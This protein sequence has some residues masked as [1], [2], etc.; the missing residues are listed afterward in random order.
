M[1]KHSQLALYGITGAL[2]L[3]I[4]GCP[5]SEDEPPK[6]TPDMSSP[7]DMGADLA[8]QPD[9]ADPPDQTQD[10]L[11]CAIIKK[12][13]ARFELTAQAQQLTLELRCTAQ[14]SLSCAQAPCASLSRGEQL[15]P[16]EL[17]EQ[18]TAAGRFDYTTTL[19]DLVPPQ[20]VGTEEVIITLPGLTTPLREQLRWGIP[21]DELTAP[22]AETSSQ[23][24]PE[25]LST[26][27]V[28]GLRIFNLEQP[29]EPS[30]AGRGQL[31]ALVSSEDGASVELWVQGSEDDQARMIHTMPTPAQTLTNGLLHITPSQ[32][33]WIGVDDAQG[34]LVGLYATFDEALELVSAQA[35][36]S[37][38]DARLK[39][40]VAQLLATDAANKP[41]IFNLGFKDNATLTITKITD[42]V[43]APLFSEIKTLGGV[44]VSAISQGSVGFLELDDANQPL[45]WLLNTAQGKTQLI[46]ASPQQDQPLATIEL[47]ATLDAPHLERIVDAQSRTSALVLISGATELLVRR[48]DQGQWAAPLALKHPRHITFKPR[49]ADEPAFTSSATFKILGQTLVGLGAGP[50][51]ERASYAS[52][53]D[54]SS[55]EL[56]QVN[57]LQAS[58]EPRSSSDPALVSA[59]DQ[60]M[61]KATPLA[62]TCDLTADRGLCLFKGRCVQ[63]SPPSKHDA[64]LCLMADTSGLQVRSAIMHADDEPRLAQASLGQPLWFSTDYNKETGLAITV[65]AA[66]D[67]DKSTHTLWRVEDAGALAE[68][69][70]LTFEPEQRGRT[71]GALA[72]GVNETWALMLE[73]A[74][75]ELTLGTFKTP[76]PQSEAALTLALQ[77]SPH[78]VPLAPQTPL[79]S[80]GPVLVNISQLTLNAPRPSQR[81]ELRPTTTPTGPLSSQTPLLIAHTGQGCG[82]LEVIALEGLGGDMPKPPRTIAK[83]DDATECDEQPAL[84]GLGRFFE[85][86]GLSIVTYHPKTRA[87][88]LSYLQDNDGQLELISKEV[89]TLDESVDSELVEAELGDWSGD[90]L[91]GIAL[92]HR[93]TTQLILIAHNGEG[94]MSDSLRRSAQF[95]PRYR[96]VRAQSAGPKRVEPPAAP[97][98]N[99]RFNPPSPLATTSSDN[100]TGWLAVSAGQSHTCAIKLDQT[101]QCWGN[102]GQAPT[103]PSGTFTQLDAGENHNCA[104]RTDGTAACWGLNNY[105]QA[106]PPIGLFKQLTAGVEFSCGIR[107]D[108]T[109]ECWGQTNNFSTVPGTFKEIRARN[110]HACGIRTDDTLFCWSWN[111]PTPAGTFI[112]IDV[113]SNTVACGL[114]SAG[115]I[116][117]WGTGFLPMQTPP[118]GTFT[119]LTTGAFHSCAIR[120]DGSLACFGADND[121]QATPPAGSFTYVT[122]GGFHTCALGTD[123]QITC[124]GNNT[125]GQCDVPAQNPAGWAT[126]DGGNGYSCGLRNNGQL[127]CWGTNSN[128]RATPP[129][130]AFSALSSGN[131]GSCAILS[132][133]QTVACWGNQH[134]YSPLVAPAGQFSQLSIGGAHACGIKTD[135]SVFCWGQN[136]YGQITTP[137]GT[138]TQISAGGLFTCGLRSDETITC[139]GQSY[140]GSLSAPAGTFTKVR[141]GRVYHSCAIR[142]DGTLACWGNNAYGQATPPSGQF[143]DVTVN[144]YSSCGIRADGSAVCW[145]Q[146]YA[147]LNAPPAGPFVKIN[148]GPFHFCAVR[149]D[150]SAACRGTN[151]V[152]ECIVP[153]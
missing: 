79:A 86:D 112:G 125:E 131:E 41:L 39:P 24:L 128:G 35:L 60:S 147:G 116:S 19:T 34:E 77:V 58:V 140:N 118:T 62:P 113:A 11:S 150:G 70:P 36:T 98:L 28:L 5:A 2:T 88:R 90:G 56:L 50:S 139:W 38:S 89:I 105:G 141:S 23:L 6:T 120:P 126:I 1:P 144:E 103:P 127:Q 3:A 114:D 75:N 68:P 151:T 81:A 124:W 132:A 4:F 111:D 29:L 100:G 85:E 80:I 119:Q 14:L 135:G 43:E 121:G 66:H 52:T 96:G 22:G 61:S 97:L 7:T 133:D 115:Q 64:G 13:P 44:A 42:Q 117:C 49:D 40:G 123:Q 18:D 92:R 53:W 59:L 145:G 110:G 87:V 8:D 26:R 143:L 76:N 152:G 47:N 101:I 138:F 20:A 106:T 148:S 142:T 12:T 30:L 9:L 146:L 107:T 82:A 134:A 32:L 73:G 67:M 91:D 10:Q 69:S 25:F 31:V 45:L 46:I 74:N 94:N 21:L 37:S 51:G 153:Q 27:R 57:Q 122:G 84:L 65:N 108:D 54:L 137:A 130:G 93:G 149:A 55:G 102:A 95:P 15:I 63:S 129:A 48:D 136:N 33:T 109:V 71:L 16:I 17:F 99:A 78:T 83:L 104:L 72:L